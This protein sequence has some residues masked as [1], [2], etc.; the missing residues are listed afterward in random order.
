SDE[1]R[2]ERA[3]W[4]EPRPPHADIVSPN[5]ALGKYAPHRPG[6]ASG[7]RKFRMVVAAC[8]Q[9]YVQASFPGSFHRVVIW[10]KV[11]KKVTICAINSIAVCRRGRSAGDSR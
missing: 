9:E 7:W 5:A 3:G 10:R 6:A 2:M 1:G 8:C 4:W 11:R